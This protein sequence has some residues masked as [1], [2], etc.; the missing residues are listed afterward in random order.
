[1]GA[2]T[3]PCPHGRRGG[4]ARRESLGAQQGSLAYHIFKGTE[5]QEGRR[6]EGR[7]VESTIYPFYLPALKFRDFPPS[8][9]PC[10]LPYSQGWLPAQSLFPSDPLHP[11]GTTLL[12][13]VTPGPR[14]ER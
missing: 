3:V 11:A 8:V 6:G 13:R 12:P 10:H 14:L 7:Q 9:G 1:M 2:A 5:P 4:I